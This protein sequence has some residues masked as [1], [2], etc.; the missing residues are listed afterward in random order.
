MY[1]VAAPP[2]RPTGQDGDMHPFRAAVEAGDTD[3]MAACLAPDV[4]F[5]SP[6]AFRPYDG[7]ELTAA[8]LRAVT[9]VMPDLHY[10]RE[11]GGEQ[12]RDLALIFEAE[13]GGRSL[14]GC[15]VL[16]MNDDGLIAELMVMVRPLSAA[17]ALAEAMGEQFPR[18]EA[19]VAGSA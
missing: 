5:I 14:T 12:D 8:I 17:Q 10:V 9:R 2:A 3:A 15:D 16:R 11:I 13:V 19:E 7:K 1:L 6:V 18:I 4:R